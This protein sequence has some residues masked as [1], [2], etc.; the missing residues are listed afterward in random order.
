V[1]WKNWKGCVMS[2][3]KIV[4][5]FEP[6]SRAASW[7]SQECTENKSKMY[8]LRGSHLGAAQA[9]SVPYGRFM[10]PRLCRYRFHDYCYDQFI[11]SIERRA[12][13]CVTDHATGPGL[14]IDCLLSS[15]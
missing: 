8:R 1:N 13:A 7:E 9:L 14:S 10:R 15:F 11:P 4:P 12:T 6:G 2:Q 5:G 3:E